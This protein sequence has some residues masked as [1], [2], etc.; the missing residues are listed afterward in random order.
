MNAITL[1]IPHLTAEV[2]LNSA[3]LIKTCSVLLRREKSLSCPQ[4]PL[5]KQNSSL[6]AQLKNWNDQTGLGIVLTLPPVL[7]A[8]W[9]RA[10]ARCYLGE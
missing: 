6:N 7:P 3:K 1:T 2:F 5:D 10:V 4:H 8:Q 9:S